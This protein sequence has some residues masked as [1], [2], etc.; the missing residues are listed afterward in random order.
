VAIG[1]EP[2]LSVR[3]GIVKLKTQPLT[4]AGA[5]FREYVLDAEQAFNERE[6]ELLERWRPRTTT[7]P[8]TPHAMPATPRAPG[9]RQKNRLAG[10]G[11]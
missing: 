2:F 9:P 8:V 1:S 7:Q 6:K 4:A 10:R 3:Y 5:R 11:E